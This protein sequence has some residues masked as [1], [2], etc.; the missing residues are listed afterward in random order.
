M[1]MKKEKR[2]VAGQT[3]IR[4]LMLF[5]NHEILECAN[6]PPRP[7]VVQYWVGYWP[8]TNGIN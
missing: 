8:G 4:G 6:S 7:V 5:I 1:S 3:Q 2:G